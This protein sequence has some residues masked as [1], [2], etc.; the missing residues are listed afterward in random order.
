MAST[1]GLRSAAIPWALGLLTACVW[2]CTGTAGAS[3]ILVQ[4]FGIGVFLALGTPLAAG[5]LRRPVE[6]ARPINVFFLGCIYFFVLDMALLR[7]A[8]EFQPETVLVA[9]TVITLFLA[10]V[11]GT[12]CLVPCRRSPLC[13]VLE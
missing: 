8:E 6:I 11:I 7:E 2:L 4:G 10:T 12:W 1:S 13:A 9:E 3:W 5:L